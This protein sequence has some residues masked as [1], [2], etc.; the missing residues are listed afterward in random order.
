MNDL[1]KKYFEILGNFEGARGFY[2]GGC[3][4]LEEFAEMERK[5]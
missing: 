2:E 5:G 4:E 1:L 3:V